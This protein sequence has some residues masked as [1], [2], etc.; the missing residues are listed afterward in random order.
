M[1]TKPDSLKRPMRG[2]WVAQLV[3]HL[4]FDFGSGH[5]H[6]TDS[7]SPSLSAPPPSQKEKKNTNEMGV[8]LSGG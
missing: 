8:S 1:Q 3:E 6:M 4:T 5:D 2:T 7:L